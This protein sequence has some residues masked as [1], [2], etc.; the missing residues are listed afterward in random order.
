[1][2][3]QTWARISENVERLSE[4]TKRLFVVHGTIKI[5][6]TLLTVSDVI[7]V[8]KTR[9]YCAVCSNNLNKTKCASKRRR[10]KDFFLGLSG[11]SG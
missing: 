8:Q 9:L 4:S 6:L 3:I 11:V 2:F 1:M 10:S 7:I 5:D